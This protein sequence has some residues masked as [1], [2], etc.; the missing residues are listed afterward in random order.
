MRPI[1]ISYLTAFHRLLPI[2]T[3]RNRMMNLKPTGAWVRSGPLSIGLIDLSAPPKRSDGWEFKGIRFNPTKAPTHQ[4]PCVRQP[5]RLPRF[6]RRTRTAGD[7]ETVFWYVASPCGIK[8]LTTHT[9]GL[10][11]PATFATTGHFPLEVR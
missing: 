8:A 1:E 4:S 7:H 6:R 10:L 5:S 3:W 9:A 11:T 2:R